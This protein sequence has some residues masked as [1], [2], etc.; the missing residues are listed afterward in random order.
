[1]LFDFRCQTSMQIFLLKETRIRTE[2]ISTM[3]I[4]KVCLQ[5]P[6]VPYVLHPPAP[7]ST[8]PKRSRHGTG[9]KLIQLLLS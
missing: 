7:G 3:G 5:K 6:A 8:E 4:N 1:M 2:E 9:V